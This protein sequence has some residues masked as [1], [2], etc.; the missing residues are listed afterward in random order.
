[1]TAQEVVTSSAGDQMEPQME[2]LVTSLVAALAGRVDEQTVAA[3]VREEYAAYAGARIT[4]FIP[5]LVEQK[6]RA[7]LA[8]APR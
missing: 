6:V 7:R 5:L 8:G 4:Q 3:A 2:P 1:M